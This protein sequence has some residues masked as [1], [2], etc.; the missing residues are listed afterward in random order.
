ML[1]RL[2]GQRCS[3]WRCH[4]S[5]YSC[6]WI[7]MLCLLC[8]EKLASLPA[9]CDL[10]LAIPACTLAACLLCQLLGKGSAK[11]LCLQAG[12]CRLQGGALH[13]ISLVRSCQVPY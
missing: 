12:N 6:C 7:S 2:P 8:S 10:A 11:G 4:R 13:D 9:S 3:A 1:L 5:T